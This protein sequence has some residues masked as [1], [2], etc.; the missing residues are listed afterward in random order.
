LFLSKVTLNLYNEKDQLLASPFAKEMAGEPAV[1]SNE[2]VPLT[3]ICPIES[4]E[5]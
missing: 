2:K 3:L 4:F 1:P 5:W